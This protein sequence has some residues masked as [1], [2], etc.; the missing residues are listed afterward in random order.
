[1]E[2]MIGNKRRRD[3]PRVVVLEVDAGGDDVE[4]GSGEDFPG[5]WG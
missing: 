4:T 2:W 5:C 1:M 3:V